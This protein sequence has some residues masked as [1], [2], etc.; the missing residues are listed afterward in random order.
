[1][2]KPRV[3]VS[4]THHDLRYLRASLESFIESLGFTPVLSEKG[5]ITYSPDQPLD[6]SCY[7]DVA[8]ADIFVLI[9]GG[10]YGSPATTEVRNQKQEVNAR[11]ES[12]TKKE[13]EMAV[14]RD[15]PTY[16][17]VE[18]NVY[19]E[20]QTY[21]GNLQNRSV[22]YAHVDSTN[23]FRFLKEILEHPRNNPI[24]K[25]DGFADIETFLRQQW[26]GLFQELLHRISEQRQLS[27]LSAQISELNKLNVTLKTYLEALITEIRPSESEQL[28]EREGAKLLEASIFTD[29]VIDGYWNSFSELTGQALDSLFSALKEVKSVD[30]FLQHAL[31]DPERRAAFA[32]EKTTRDELLVKINFFRRQLGCDEIQH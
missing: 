4:S 2:P 28:I 6:E 11:Y 20:F 1:M 31:I 25:F 24:C 22:K 16:I 5:A 19:S 32:E 18:S 7:R 8:H 29:F 21:L 13:Y 14:Q 3:F 15:I 17:L 27:A 10:R 26:S 30:A 12:I 23:I 9:L